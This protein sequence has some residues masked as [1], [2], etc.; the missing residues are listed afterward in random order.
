[1]VTRTG[2]CKYCG[3][4][5]QTRTFFKFDGLTDLKAQAR[6]LSKMPEL[7]VDRA[8]VVSEVLGG[9]V[10]VTVS[11]DC[12]YLLWFENGETHCGAHGDEW[13]RRVRCTVYPESEDEM[14]PDGQCGY[15]LVE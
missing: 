15:S 13:K 4:C 8:H 1:M 11:V 5:C 9:G 6:A 14:R 2:V 10:V 12:E 7:K 3:W